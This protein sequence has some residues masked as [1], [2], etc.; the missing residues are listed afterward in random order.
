MR[1]K[2]EDK[3][4]KGLSNPKKVIIKEVNS[5]KKI[6]LKQKRINQKERN[7]K[8]MCKCNCLIL[9]VLLDMIA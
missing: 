7:P 6:I 8:F 3:A 9:L 5:K 2:N 1:E 4:K